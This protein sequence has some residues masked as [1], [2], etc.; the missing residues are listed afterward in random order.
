MPWARSYAASHQPA[1]HRMKHAERKKQKAKTPIVRYVVKASGMVVTVEVHNN[2]L[3]NIG[4]CSKY[5]L[6]SR[7]SGSN[8]NSSVTGDKGMS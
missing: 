2:T 3:V 4:R 8:M 6:L 1:R 5:T 7:N